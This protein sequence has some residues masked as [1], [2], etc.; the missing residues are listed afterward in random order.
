MN[1]A[2]C[3]RFKRSLVLPIVLLLFLPAQ[4]RAAETTYPQQDAQFSIQVPERLK[5]IYREDSLV[6]LPIPEDGFLIQVHEQPAAAGK[7]LG[8]ITER[9][10]AQMKLSD[11]ELGTAAAAE[12]Q[13]EVECTIM[14][15]T[16]QAD[17][18]SI[19]ITVVAFSIEDE[20]HFTIQSVGA[21]DLN[22]KHS[23]ELLNIVD[24][25]KPQ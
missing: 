18:K 25:I 23:G 15:S 22:K 10:A 14:T 19:V 5:P 17:G 13:H 1:E 12:N 6:L 24:S 20:K 8:P 16:A 4:L 3:S 11:L 2:T 21:S 9:I 7:S